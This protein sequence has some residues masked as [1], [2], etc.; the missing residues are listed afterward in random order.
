MAQGL[1]AGKCPALNVNV[2]Q[3]FLYGSPQATGPNAQRLQGGQNWLPPLLG[4]STVTALWAQG[5]PATLEGMAVTP[6]WWVVV[7]HACV[8]EASCVP[9]SSHD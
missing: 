4:H 3:D 7:L 1:T 8:C 5:C 2:K 9:K 6:D